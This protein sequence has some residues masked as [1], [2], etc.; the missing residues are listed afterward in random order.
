M[1]Q[2]CR[3]KIILKILSHPPVRSGTS[4]RGW[5]NE[6]PEPRVRGGVSGQRPKKKS[7]YTNLLSSKTCT[8][9]CYD[10]PFLFGY[11]LSFSPYQFS[12]LFLTSRF[13][14]SCYLLLFFIPRFSPSLSLTHPPHVPYLWLTDS[15]HDSF[16]SLWLILI[17]D[18]CLYSDLPMGI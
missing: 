3:R 16:V 6:D 9:Q 17:L 13:I 14:Y 8:R 7:D 2:L 1:W 18:L 10:F 5:W 15:S 4:S 12:S 11:V